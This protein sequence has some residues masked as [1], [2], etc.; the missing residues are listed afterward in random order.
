[1]NRY[2]IFIFIIVF[3]IKTEAQTSVLNA[4]DNLYATG[5]YSKAI[6][7]YQLYDSPSEVFEKIAKSFL[8]LGNYGEALSYYSKALEAHPNNVFLKFDYAKVLYNIKKYK[9]SSL[10][11]GQLIE[12]DAKNPNYQYELGQTLEALQD[13]TA[14]N[15]Y[16]TAFQLDQTHQKA[17]YKIAR[18]HLI[19]R[20][21][22]ESLKYI[23]IGLKSYENN[24]ELISLKAQNYYWMQEYRES[25]AWFELL[26]ALGETSQFIHES[27]RDCYLQHF[28][29]KEAAEQ[30]LLALQYDPKNVEN[31][32]TQGELY[33]ELEEFK[34]AEEYMVLALQLKD[35]PL[36]I[37]YRKLGYVYNRQAKYKEA[38][39]A[40]TMSLKENPDNFLA[41]FYM[42][43]A[44]D[45]YYKDIDTRLKLYEQFVQKY[46]ESRYDYWIDKRIKEL[47]E[48]KFM[49]GED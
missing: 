15:F 28:N 9:E 44:K 27:L 45:K 23:N 47:K 46:P 18:H 33:Q 7:Q 30:G 49:K 4:A 31:M 14:M 48:E 26:I 37:L 20:E 41:E 24:V 38:I 8:A 11:F 32:F 21:H 19:E 35:T 6:E 12:L 43:N 34:K 13:S 29:Y 5:N 25:A 17:I 3:S 39:D 16:R 36:D 40:L 10:L 2:I 1:M 42:L 22:D